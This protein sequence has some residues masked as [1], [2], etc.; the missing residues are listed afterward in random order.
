MGRISRW[1]FR[2][3][4]S[5]HKI[6]RGI[7]ED[8]AIER[9]GNDGVKGRISCRDNGDGTLDNTAA[10][11]V[12]KVL[13]LSQRLQLIRNKWPKTNAISLEIDEE[14]QG[15]GR[16][17]VENAVSR[18]IEGRMEGGLGVL[19]VEDLEQRVDV[20]IA[21]GSLGRERRRGMAYEEI[22]VEEPDV[23]LDSCAACIESGK[24][25]FFPPV[26]IV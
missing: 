25:R 9:V 18:S 2:S 8:I 20:E 3:H 12:G 15:P 1:G 6:Q 4:Q 7:E 22:V 11:K 23:S 17:G 5:L 19:F 24:E 21:Q 13:A 16:L 14:D 26:V 10:I